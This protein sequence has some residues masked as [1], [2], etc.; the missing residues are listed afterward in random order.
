MWYCACHVKFCMTKW[1]ISVCWGHKNL[2]TKKWSR[3]PKRGLRTPENPHT[4]YASCHVVKWRASSRGVRCLGAKRR[5]HFFFGPFHRRK[6]ADGGALTRRRAADGANEAV[7]SLATNW[8]VSAKTGVSHL[9]VTE[10]H[11]VASRPATGPSLSPRGVIL[12]A[13]AHRRREKWRK[14]TGDITTSKLRTAG[15]RGGVETKRPAEEKCARS[16]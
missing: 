6:A 12:I 13:R 9:F 10:E 4:L 3:E 8:A 15:G 2:W 5:F 1:Q 16:S 11:L 7:G 14:E